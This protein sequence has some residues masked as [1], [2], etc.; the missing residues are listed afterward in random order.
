MDGERLGELGKHGAL[1]HFLCEGNHRARL[2]FYNYHDQIEE[3][4]IDFA[5]SR[6]S[7]F[8]V[9][10]VLSHDGILSFSCVS[11]V[12]CSRDLYF[13]LSAYEPDDLKVRIYPPER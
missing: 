9:T 1:R 3:H 11:E 8:D 7:L 5:V 4:A 2:R 12:P 6:P 13:K 10:E